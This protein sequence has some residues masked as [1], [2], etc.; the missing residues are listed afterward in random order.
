MARQLRV[1]SALIEHVKRRAN[2]ANLLDVIKPSVNLNPSTAIDRPLSGKGISMGSKGVNAKVIQLKKEYV[3]K[4]GLLTT[5][6]AKLIIKAIFPEKLLP[7]MLEPESYTKGQLEFALDVGANALVLDYD[8]YVGFNPR[9]LIRAAL[10]LWDTPDADDLKDEIGDGFDDLS[11]IGKS[12]VK[13]YTTV[14]MGTGDVIQYF[15]KL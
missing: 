1:K 4:Y 12:V 8:K 2:A 11:A 10:D 15:E 5:E 6:E 7:E 14:V 13:R 3:D 9:R